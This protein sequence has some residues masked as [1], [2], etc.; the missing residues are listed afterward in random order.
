MPT[1]GQSTAVV[2]HNAYIAATYTIVKQL[3][4]IFV[5]MPQITFYSKRNFSN[6]CTRR[7]SLTV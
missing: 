3:T 5:I 1:L 2:M 7:K 6:I 4:N